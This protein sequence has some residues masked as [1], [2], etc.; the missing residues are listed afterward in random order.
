VGIS[1]KISSVDEKLD[2]AGRPFK[3]K[4]QEFAA[5]KVG[6][7]LLL[8]LVMLPTTVTLPGRLLWVA[9][10][11]SVALGFVTPD[12]MLK[13]VIRRRALQMEREFADVLDLVRVTVE[14]GMSTIRAL[15]EVGYW[16]QGLLAQELEYST[17]LSKLGLNSREILE[18]LRRRC[19]ISGV[20]DLVS[21]IL[22]ANKYGTSLVPVL[23]QYSESTRSLQ[24]RAVLERSAKAGPK[25]QLVVALVMVPSVMLLVVASILSSFSVSDVL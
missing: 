14:S 1:V 12:L 11:A 5:I 3:L 8:A 20:N 19:P 6:S 21:L 22:R 4:V 7:A 16:Q 13:G 17:S 23:A 18:T 25:I 2:A 24:Q 9:V 15:G 10:P